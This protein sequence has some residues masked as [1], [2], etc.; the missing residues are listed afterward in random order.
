MAEPVRP[1]VISQQ[2]AWEI[3]QYLFDVETQLVQAL[4]YAYQHGQA[5]DAYIVGRAEMYADFHNRVADLTGDQQQ[6]GLAAVLERA[7]RAVIE[8]GLAQSSYQLKLAP[9][10]ITEF[11][12]H[13]LAGLVWEANHGLIEGL[14]DPIGA[15]L[16]GI[17]DAYRQV[18]TE[19]IAAAA[20]GQTGRR[21]ATQQAINRYADLGVTGF[22]TKDGKR[23]RTDTYAEMTARTTLGRAALHAATTLFTDF[24][25]PVVRVTTSPETCPLCAPWEHQLLA[26]DGITGKRTFDHAVTGKPVTVNVKATIREAQ[27]AGLWHPN[28][29]HGIDA[30]IPGM[31]STAPTK[32]DPRLYELSQ[33]QRYLERQARKWERRRD[34]ALSEEVAQAADQRRQAYLARIRALTNTTR[35]KRKPERE[36]T[37]LPR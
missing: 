21:Q 34:V 35:L 7:A 18:A 27:E 17:Q 14:G 24:G 6:R 23:W 37:P 31:Q 1:L 15:M 16:R 33:Q 30:Y 29:R 26:L 20:A 32:P 12:Q 25:Y 13:R 8:A 3:G 22:T 4:A 10:Q 19:T 2:A 28:C 36:T 5:R 9:N 11:T